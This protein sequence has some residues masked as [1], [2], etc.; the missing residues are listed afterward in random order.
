MGK[1]HNL[2]PKSEYHYFLNVTANKCKLLD[3][4]KYIDYINNKI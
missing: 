2:D 3:N 4:N 1:K